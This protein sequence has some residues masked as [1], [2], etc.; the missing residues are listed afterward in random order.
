MTAACAA[1]M[2]MASVTKTKPT[3]NEVRRKYLC[4]FIVGVRRLENRLTARAKNMA[5]AEICDVRAA[6]Y[7]TLGF[8]LVAQTWTT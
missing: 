7:V 3:A 8:F 4:F 1:A 5:G 2:A 6:P